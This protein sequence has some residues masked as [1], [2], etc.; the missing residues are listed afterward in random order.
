M[1]IIKEIGQLKK[2]KNYQIK[3]GWREQEE[4]FHELDHGVHKVF[5]NLIFLPIP[6]QVL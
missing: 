6:V 4:E 1:K 5:T 2:I 3:K